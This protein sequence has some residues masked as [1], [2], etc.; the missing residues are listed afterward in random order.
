M[1]FNNSG[2][3]LGG[4]VKGTDPEPVTALANF[5][6]FAPYL[7]IDTLIEKLFLIISTKYH[8]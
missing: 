4:Q 3:L 8:Y 2:P 6:K 1:P 7:I 5:F